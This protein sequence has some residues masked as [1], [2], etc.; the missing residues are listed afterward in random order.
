VLFR[1]LV[2]SG[3]EAR[4]ADAG[5]TVMAACSEINLRGVPG[6]LIS[7]IPFGDDL[8]IEKTEGLA[9]PIYHKKIPCDITLGIS[10]IF[11]APQAKIE[12]THGTA[13]IVIQE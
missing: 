5:Q 13:I 6:R 3:K 11:T 2:R 4:I 10:N 1:S 8:F 12:I 7:I 9:Y